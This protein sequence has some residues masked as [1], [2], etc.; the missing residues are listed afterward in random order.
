MD[1]APIKAF[2]VGRC[3]KTVK[4][5]ALTSL[6]EFNLLAE[7]FTQGQQEE[8]ERARWQMFLLMQMHPYIKQ[9]N[10][11][12]TPK[13]WIPFEWEKSKKDRKPNAPIKCKITKKEK[14]RLMDIVSKMK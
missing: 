9:H 12:K 4:E 11:A 2:L 1:Y 8:W 5:A 7:G 3:R 6:E 14:Q 10:K 13:D